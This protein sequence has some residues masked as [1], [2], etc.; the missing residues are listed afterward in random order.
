MSLGG[1]YSRCVEIHPKE[2]WQMGFAAG[3]HP[4]YCVDGFYYVCNGSPDWYAES[5]KDGFN[6]GVES[7]LDDKFWTLAAE[8]TKAI[9]EK[10]KRIREA[11]KR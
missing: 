10:F 8:N 2:A 11:H 1:P 7:K 3:H 9:R 5:Y 4:P 6:H